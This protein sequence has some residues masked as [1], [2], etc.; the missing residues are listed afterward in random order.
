MTREHLEDL[1]VDEYA[2]ECVDLDP[3]ALEDEFV[4]LPADLAYWNSRYA[5]T[6]AEYQRAKFHRE[7]V[8]ARLHGEVREDLMEQA[9]KAAFEAHQKAVVDAQQAAEEAK[10]AGKK[11]S[12]KPVPKV[13]IK[14]PTIDDIKAE[15]TN[16]LEYVGARELEIGKEA[17][18]AHLY[19]IVDGVRCKR[20]M[21]IQIGANRRA[22]MQGDPQLRNETQGTRDARTT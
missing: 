16:H 14:S 19:G 8:A 1:D 13:S 21:L 2:I 10:A 5:H 6:A 17:E 20:D 12:T 3:L 4:R 18:K 7:Q 22:E 9:K 15:V 11:P